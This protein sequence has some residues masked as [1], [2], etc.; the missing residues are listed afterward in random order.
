[1]NSDFIHIPAELLRE[2][3]FPCISLYMPTFRSY[4]ERAQDPLRFKNLVTKA[5]EQGLAVT[6][7]RQLQPLLDRM[8]QLLDDSRFWNHA[9]DGLAVFVSENMFKVLVLHQP[10]VE[11]VHVSAMFYVKPLLRIFQTDDR[12]QVLALTRTD[13]RFYEGTRYLFDEIDPAP[14]VPKTMTDALGTEITPPHQTIAS[15]GNVGGEGSMRHGHSSRRDEEEIDNER[16]FRAVD[17]AI[18]EHH[19]RP[20]GLPLVLVALPEHQSLFRSIS[21]NPYLSAE[22]VSIDPRK[23][24]PGELRDRAWAVLEPAWKQRVEETIAQ[25]E[26]LRSKALAD[27]D[28]FVISRAAVSGR[29]SKLLLDNDRQ[30]SGTLDRTSGAIVIENGSSANGQD[31][32]DELALIVLDT[33]GEVIVIPSDRMPSQTGVAALFRYPEPVV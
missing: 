13:V 12:F 19:S 25:Y 20:S 4:P 9:L 1:M 7:K 10:V 14:E 16:F 32:L 18:T 15:F 28:P 5:K 21:H 26:Q 2:Q 29:I 3:P 8:S 6:G 27:D 24:E 30:L 33:G 22:G 17:K 23:M 11:Q 31:V